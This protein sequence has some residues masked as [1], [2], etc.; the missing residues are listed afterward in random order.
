MVDIDDAVAMAEE[1]SNA[2]VDSAEFVENIFIPIW[3]MSVE[4]VLIWAV[5]SQ[6]H[7]WFGWGFGIGGS[8]GSSNTVDAYW[9]SWLL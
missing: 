4:F 1:G 3:Y 6:T 8:V 2:Q 5:G 7:C 9:W